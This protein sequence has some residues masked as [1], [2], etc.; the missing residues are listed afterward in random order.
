MRLQIQVPEKEEGDCVSNRLYD[1]RIHTFHT[2][3]YDIILIVGKLLSKL[4]HRL[5]IGAIKV[6]ASVEGRTLMR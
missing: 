2:C 3:G 6:A 4:I 5:E 1:K